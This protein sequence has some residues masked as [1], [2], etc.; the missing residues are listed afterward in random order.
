VKAIRSNLAATG[1]RFLFA[2]VAPLAARLPEALLVGIAVIS[3]LL[4]YL[5][6]AGPRGAVDRNLRVVVPGLD[7]RARRRLALATFIHGALGYVELFRLSTY[8]EARLKRAFH[9]TGWEH[10]DAAL[11]RGHGAIVVSAHVGSYSVAGQLFAFRGC[12]T[13]MVVEPLQPPELFARVAALRSRF[14]AR[15]IPADRSA[16]RAILTALRA[17]E[18]VGMMCDRDVTGSGEMMSFFEQPA[19]LSFAPAT[20]ALRSGAAVLPAVAY[21]TRPFQGILRIDP[22]FTLQRSGDTA[23]DVQEGMTQILS[24]I[25]AMIREAPQ[26]WAMFSDVWPRSGYN[27][28]GAD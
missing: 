24:R 4:G 7:A 18:V 23:A 9:S 20:F 27:G 26:Q 11:A 6:A 21:R 8:G 14:G 22:P 2:V 3:G 15:L 1:Q 25:E 13:G 10:F 28:A 5:L 16:V 12:P 19:R 17:N